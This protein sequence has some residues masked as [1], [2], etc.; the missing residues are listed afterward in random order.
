[1]KERGTMGGEPPV[2]RICRNCQEWR[3]GGHCE[4]WDQYKYALTA[5]CRSFSPRNERGEQ[6]KQAPA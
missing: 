1:M 6:T 3:M 4:Y 5:A 2:E